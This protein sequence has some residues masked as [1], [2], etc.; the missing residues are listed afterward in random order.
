MFLGFQLIWISLLAV[1]AADVVLH[2][3][4]VHVVIDTDVVVATADIVVHFVGVHFVVDADVID[5]AVAVVMMF[6]ISKTFHVSPNLICFVKRSL[7]FD[8][9]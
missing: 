4:E 1:A 8:C 3:V 9:G 6:L 7:I 2:V 5:D